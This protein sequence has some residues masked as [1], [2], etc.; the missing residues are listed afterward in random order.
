M[1]TEHKNH[2]KH[3]LSLLNEQITSLLSYEDY[4]PKIEIDIVKNN[5][6]KLY[7]L[8]DSI[9]DTVA[10]TNSITHSKVDDIDKEI[11]DL[12][13]NAQ[14]QFTYEYEQELDVKNINNKI[15]L[16]TPNEIIEDTT[17]FIEEII[18]SIISAENISEIPV[19]TKEEVKQTKAPIINKEIAIENPNQIKRETPP[20]Q[21][22]VLEEK[23]TQEIIEEAKENVQEEVKISKTPKQKQTIVK[24]K[25]TVHI[26]EVAPDDELEEE[27]D[28]EKEVL[29]AKALKLKS[30]KSLKNGIGI[31]DKFMIINDLFEGRTKEFNAAILKLDSNKDM[32]QA[33]YM[34]GDMK[35]ENLWESKDRTFK[36]F[37]KYIQ[38]RY[39]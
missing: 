28:I 8:I 16:D 20:T 33:L 12:L 11:N 34:L 26:L 6:R 23:Q 17:Q 35:D 30:I 3:L 22:I 29:L 7:E 9:N 21:Q 13:D 25:K 10:V 14:A 5:M 1:S 27:D 18:E 36:I 24:S 19:D 15:D 4:T 2:G 39:I 32:Q 31:N 37:K 38:R